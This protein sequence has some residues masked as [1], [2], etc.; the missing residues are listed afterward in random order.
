MKFSRVDLEMRIE[1][2]REGEDFKGVL[3][4]FLS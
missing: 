2:W 1:R 4:K 3:F